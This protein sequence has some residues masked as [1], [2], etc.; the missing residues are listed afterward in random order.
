L[1]VCNNN[2][3]TISNISHLKNLQ[4]FWASGN[5]L[6]SFEELKVLATCPKLIAVYLEQNPWCRSSRYVGIIREYLPYL[7]QIDAAILKWE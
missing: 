7:R 2:I 4:E 3:A 5:K 1:D 6:E